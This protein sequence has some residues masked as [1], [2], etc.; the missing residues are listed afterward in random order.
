MKKVLIIEDDSYVRF[1]LKELLTGEGYNVFSA[2]NGTEGTNM[3]REIIPDIIICD[4]MMPGQD[5]YQ[6][7]R[8]MRDKDETANI[9]F[10]FLTAKAEM[11]DLRIGM[12]LGADDYIIKPFESKTLINAIET[13]ISKKTKTSSL[14][15]IKKPKVKKP[16]NKLTSE[17][18]IYV[19]S[20]GQLE[21]VKISNIMLIHALGNYCKIVTSEK[22]HEIIRKTLKEWEI[23]L[24]ETS[25]L[26]IHRSIIIN[27][28][29]VVEISKW[30]SGTYKVYIKDIEEPFSLSQ[31]YALQLKKKLKI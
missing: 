16:K 29:F 24:P 30:T 31:R 17:D 12:D 22:K 7:L 18:R 26:R 8:Q 20:S 25:F 23:L 13:R 14:S 11:K 6:V 1:G 5:G 27:L 2:E 4:I 9:P 21:F 28:N 15:N 3:A 19:E 10:I